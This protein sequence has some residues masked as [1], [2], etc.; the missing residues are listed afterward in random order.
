LK[1]DFAVEVNQFVNNCL[2]NIQYFQ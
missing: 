2:R 1:W